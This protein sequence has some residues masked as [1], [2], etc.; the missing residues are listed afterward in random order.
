MS[1][2]HQR[3]SLRIT[4]YMTPEEYKA[5]DNCADSLKEYWQPEDECHD[6]DWSYGNDWKTDN[7]PEQ[8]FIGNDSC[9]EDNTSEEYYTYNTDSTDHFSHLP[10]YTYAYDS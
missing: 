7:V 9:L 8:L 1:V 5:R 3:R 10:Y 6:T 4:D 2:I